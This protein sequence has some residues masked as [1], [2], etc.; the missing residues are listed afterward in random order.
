MYPHV[1]HIA[2]AFPSPRFLPQSQIEKEKK[3]LQ[4]ME[5]GHLKT[6]PSQDGLSQHHGKFPRVSDMLFDLSVRLSVHR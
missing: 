6:G 5:T 2:A 3:Q 1:F 4:K